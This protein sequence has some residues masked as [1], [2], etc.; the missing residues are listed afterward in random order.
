MHMLEC[1]LQ[2]VMCIIMRYLHQL[3]QLSS[4]VYKKICYGPPPVIVLSDYLKKIQSR[5]Y[6]LYC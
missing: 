3:S 5:F 6:V 4:P 1:A 2:G